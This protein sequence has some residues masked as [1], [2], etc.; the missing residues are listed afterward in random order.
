MTSRVLSACAT[1]VVLPLAA[2]LLPTLMVAQQ[3]PAKGPQTVWRGEVWDVKAYGTVD[4]S[5]NPAMY[6]HDISVDFRY[7]QETDRDGRTHFTSRR[8]SWQADGRSQSAAQLNECKGSGSLELGPS[9]SVDAITDEHARALR[10]PCTTRDFMT[11]FTF[12][13]Q[14]PQRISVPRIVDWEKLREGCSYSEERG[15]ERYTVSVAPEIEGVIELDT[16]FGG[17][18]WAFEPLPGRSFV[19]TVTTR[20]STPAYFKFVLE[21]NEVSRFPGYASNANVDAAFFVKAG[22]TDLQGRYPNDGPDLLFAP[23]DYTDR[24]LWRTADD[25]AV[26]TAR[27]ETTAAVTVTAMDYGATGRL[28][29]FVKGV[30]GG[31]Q[32][33]GVRVNGQDRDYV[34]LPMDEDQNLIADSLDVYRGDPGRDDDAE[35][36]GDGTGGDGLTA[37]EE[38]RG[39]LTQGGDCTDRSQDFHLRTDPTRKDLFV[40]TPDPELSAMLSSFAW[41]SELIVHAICEPHYG[42]NVSAGALDL[43][44]TDHVVN[45]TLQLANLRSWLGRTISQQT[46]QRGLY[47]I[48]EAIGDGVAGRVCQTGFACGGGTRDEMRFGSPKYTRVVKVDKRAHDDSADLHNTIVHELGHAVGIT[49]HADEL[50]ARRLVAPGVKNYKRIVLVPGPSCVDPRIGHSLVGDEVY[51]DGVFVG[52]WALYIANR[53]GTHSGNADCPM[54]YTSA[55]F[56]VAPDSELRPQGDVRYNQYHTPPENIPG[57]NRVLPLVSGRVLTYQN[58]MDPPGLGQFCALKT[59]TGINA[60]PG[61]G[62]HAGDATSGR[63]RSRI[64][65]NDVRP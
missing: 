8:I 33:V 16:R 47:L 18:Y 44:P 14:P 3:A 55:S 36:S 54:K 29:A 21:P 2:L 52:C 53:K 60:L 22:L 63:C 65:V 58:E 37:F 9:S 30:C 17:A 49:H 31:W 42:N 26:E 24:S 12:I 50:A 64:V 4:T 48:D 10:I 28:R 38:Y 27:P 51:M 43:G 32:P 39:F 40:H 62:N 20:P 11:H 25:A 57:G 45:F 56:Y 7:V 46:P 59:G 15:S 41:S 34:S 19:M 23:R 35:P 61:D 6:Q 1:A 5:G 13:E